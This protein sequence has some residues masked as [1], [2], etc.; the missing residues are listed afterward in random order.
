MAASDAS[1]FIVK[2]QAY[3]LTGLILNGTTGN[4]ITGGLTALSASVSKD[5]ASTFTATSNS[6]TEQGTTGWFY[7]DLTATEM[8]AN[9]ICVRVT[10]SNSDAVYFKRVLIPADLS[11]PSGHARDATVLRLEQFL[12]QLHMY[13]FNKVVRAIGTGTISLYNYGATAVKTTMARLTGTDYIGKDE[14]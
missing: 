9:T 7:V 10:A 8:N 12:I 3:R 14:G 5:G 6:A 11:E 2:N 13:W 4:E 1:Q